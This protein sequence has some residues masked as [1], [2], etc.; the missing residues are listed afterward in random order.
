MNVKDNKSYAEGLDTYLGQVGREIDA[1]IAM[2][3]RENLEGTVHET[4]SYKIILMDPTKQGRSYTPR[5]STPYIAYRVYE[6]ALQRSQQDC[7]QLYKHLSQQDNMRSAAGWFFKRYAHD[8]FRKGGTFNI[9]EIPI[10]SRK[11][12][13][14]FSFH[15][16]KSRV[17]TPNYF[18]T[19]NDLAKKVR[20]KR[21]K[22]INP[23]QME[24][25]FLPFCSNYG[26]IDGLLF[27]D[28]QTI[29]L[30]QITLAERHEIMPHAV[31]ELVKALPT[32]IRNI[33]IVF[34]IPQNRSENYSKAQ[35]VPDANTVDQGRKKL[36]VK[37]FRLIL[38]DQYIKAVSLQGPLEAPE[39]NILESTSKL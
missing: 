8:W 1:F 18:T 23:E 31:T 5:F 35:N 26:S 17:Q 38:R 39:E 37:Q 30:F 32:T 27:A 22:G 25:Y 24:K 36:K 4:S 19:V 10:A 14:N 34:V 29:V 33:Q 6:K 13:S 15:I 21:G 20:A 9:E 2:G 28:S 11:S 12:S 3:G 7:F 16:K